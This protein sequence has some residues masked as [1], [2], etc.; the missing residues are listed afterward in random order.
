MKKL[1]LTLGVAVL[2]ASAG[3]VRAQTHSASSMTISG[4]AGAASTLTVSS[5]VGIIDVRRWDAVALQPTFALSG[6]GVGNVVFNFARSADGAT[7]ETTPSISGTIAASGTTTVSGVLNV[8]TG[9]AATIK[10]VSVVN[11]NN[12]GVVP[13]PVIKIGRKPGH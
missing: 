10:L 11:A 3:A 6:T 12:P 13:N 1:L 7:Y 5:T 9:G 2:L 4:T 8:S